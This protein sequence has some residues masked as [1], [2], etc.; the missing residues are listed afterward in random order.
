[1]Q[2]YL[3][4]LLLATQLPTDGGSLYAETDLTKFVAE[5]WNAYSSLT[6]LIPV[7]YWLFRLRGQY[8]K[9]IFLTCCMPLLTLGGIGSTVFHAFRSSPYF[10]LLDVVPIAI[11]T[12]S[13]S[14]YFWW[15]VIGRWDAVLILAAAYVV[16]R[17]TI[18]SSGFF[19]PHQGVNIS[20]FI[21]GV[22]LFLPALLLL[23]SMNF[24]GAK[25]IVLATAFF[26]VALIFR[27]IDITMNLLPMGTHWLW[28][29]SCAIGAFFL[30]EYLYLVARIERQNIREVARQMVRPTESVMI[31]ND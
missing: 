18:V 8:R 27:R 31:N 14:L 2:L 1:M 11:L 24:K 17:L 28:H 21:T 20:Y 22:M 3:T 26:I 5:P 15:R 9:Y 7:I 6:F 19:S 16:A 13:V 30:A 4:G 29:V 10:L 25:Q 23:R 12:L